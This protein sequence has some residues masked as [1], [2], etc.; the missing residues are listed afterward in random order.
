MKK[1]VV[2][3]V[4]YGLVCVAV[5]V[6]LILG[7]ADPKRPE[8]ARESADGRSMGPA[9]DAGTSIPASGGDSSV[10]A[11]VGPDGLRWVPDEPVGSGSG[12]RENA[13]GSQEPVQGK[14]D[15]PAWVGGRLPERGSEL[16]GLGDPAI[17]AVAD[18][19]TESGMTGAGLEL[20]LRGVYGHVQR[21]AMF[22]MLGD[23]DL[24]HIAQSEEQAS[25]AGPTEGPATD[26][27]GW[28]A[29]VWR[30]R[31]L[32]YARYV[33]RDL[34]T[35]LGITDGRVVGRLATI[36]DELSARNTWQGTGVD[37]GR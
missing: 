15:P 19:L 23:L 2:A 20:A 35:R 17:L 32:E 28:R 16:L 24:S 31:S 37:Q 5:G 9:A 11:E 21:L 8:D 3:A 22:K 18:L 6:A 36:A 27:L 1:D 10:Q 30:S 34:E 26:S 7:G 13:R 33:R 29:D 12:G 4:A 25:R 14:A